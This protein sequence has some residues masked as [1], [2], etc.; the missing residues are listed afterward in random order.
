MAALGGLTLLTLAGTSS[1]FDPR[2]HVSVHL[3]PFSPSSCFQRRGQRLLL[4]GAD[5]APELDLQQRHDLCETREELD[6]QHQR[7]C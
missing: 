5:E 2:W 6:H 7:L 4:P 3:K 1:T